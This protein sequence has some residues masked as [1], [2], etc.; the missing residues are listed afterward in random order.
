MNVRE[1]KLDAKGLK[2]AIV[3]SKFNAF[4]GDKL[5]DGALDAF[6]QLGGDE[7]NIDLVKVP[8]AYE[9]AGIVRSLLN[10]GKHD[11]V[12]CLGVIIQ[13]QTPH[14]EYV[15]GNSAKAIMELAS[16]GKTPVIYGLITASD[17]EQAVDR[18]GVKAGNKGYD[19]MMNAVEMA[20]LYKVMK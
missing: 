3:F 16:E 6:S 17:L 5:I 10:A 18:A 14:F 11:A 2:V 8:G 13:G 4:V 19:A 20:N 15:A 12:I 9:I 7:A 1:G